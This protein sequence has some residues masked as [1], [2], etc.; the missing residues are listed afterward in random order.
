MRQ[1]CTRVTTREEECSEGGGYVPD[2]LIPEAA[3]FDIQLASEKVVW[4]VFVRVGVCIELLG[5]TVESISSGEIGIRRWMGEQGAAAVGA[6]AERPHGIIE[7]LLVARQHT[8][9]NGVNW[10]FHG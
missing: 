8:K 3:A 7:C 1:V 9:E 6:A 4:T 5:V 2:I 10:L